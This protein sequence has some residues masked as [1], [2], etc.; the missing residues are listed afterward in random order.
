[1]TSKGR[2][3]GKVV[4]LMG[5]GSVGEGIGNGRASALVYAREGASVFVVDRSREAAEATAGAIASQGGRSAVGVGDV[6]N[7]DDVGR[8]VRECLEAF[9]RIDI[10]HNNVAVVLVGSVSELSEES[11]DLSCNVNL[12]S[13][14]LSCRHVVPHMKAQKSGAII[15]ISSIAA[16]RYLGVPYT[17]YYATKAGIVQLTRAMAVELAPFGVRANTILPGFI[18]T[19]HVHAFLRDHL[20]AGDSAALVE[21]RGSQTPMG[22]MGTGW[23]VAN[24]ALFLASD[25][26]GYITATELIVDGGVSAVAA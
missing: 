22:H 25:E 7:D 18:D 23:D 24:A 13:V 14:F 5:G 12:K 4:L 16:H 6:A 17:A 10:L 19:P 26:A 8:L 21:K 3:A 1:M 9:G 11:W 15:N 20:G 2:V